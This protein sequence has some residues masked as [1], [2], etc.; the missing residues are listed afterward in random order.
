MTRTRANA[1]LLVAG[2]TWGMGFIAQST[3]MDAIGPHLFIAL[4]FVIASLAVLPLAWRETRRATAPLRPR[5]HLA[6]ASVGMVFFLA[7]A[8]QQ[9]GLLTTT[10]TN[11]GFLTG[12]Y[13]VFTPL[14]AVLLFREWPHRVIWPAAA[15][16]LLGIFLLGGGSL[17]ALVVG[18]LLTV[19][20]AVFWAAQVVLIGRVVRA[21]GR[22]MALAFTQFATC[23]GLAALVALATEPIAWEAIR[24]AGPEILYAGFVASAFAF[25]VQIVAQRHTTAPQAAIMLSSESLFAALFAALFLGERLAAIGLLGCLLLFA[26]MLLVELVPLLRPRRAGPEGGA[27]RHAS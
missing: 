24:R 1:L 27:P 5:D 9:V 6:H 19:V 2:A 13:V 11:S 16:A 3:A 8:F 14:I 17:S 15:L 18:D 26:S 20:C 12:L 4:R 10:V 21:G 22:P 23:A 7:M 25:T